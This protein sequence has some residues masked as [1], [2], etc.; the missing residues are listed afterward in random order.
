MINTVFGK[1]CAEMGVSPSMSSVGDAYDNAT[2]ES[3]IA[4]LKCKLTHCGP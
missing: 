1:R 4:S 3:F 2:A